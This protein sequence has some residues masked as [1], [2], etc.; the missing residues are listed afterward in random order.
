MAVLD[1]VAA[2]EL[3]VQLEQQ[4]ER[5]VVGAWG[6]LD[7]SSANEFE[8]KLRQA[9]RGSAFGV[10][11]DL[12]GVTFMDSIGMHVLVSAAGLAHGIGRELVVLRGSEHVRQVI[13]TSGVD[14]L[15]PLA[16]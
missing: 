5:V 3:G 1:P 9:I 2:D 7:V 4:G 8:V 13:E 14:D 16:D 10:V 15:L 6:E 11:L 12:G